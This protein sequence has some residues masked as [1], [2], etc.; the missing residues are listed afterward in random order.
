MV[1]MLCRL[2]EE[3]DTTHFPLSY[4]PLIYFCA[5]VGTSFNWAD[6]LSENLKNVIS[7]V[8]QAQPGSF[9]NFH[10]DSYILDIMCIA[11]K[12]SNMGWSWLS[13]DVAIH[14]YYKVLWEPQIPNKLSKDL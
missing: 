8:T 1:D 12:Y 4:M 10:M 13:T 11:H 6:I 5:N 2:Y 7:Y 14:I 9:P 3:P